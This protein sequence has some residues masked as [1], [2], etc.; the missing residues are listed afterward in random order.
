M[1]RD[2]RETPLVLARLIQEIEHRGLDYSGLYIRQL[3]YSI[4]DDRIS[5]MIVFE[6]EITI[7]V[8]IAAIYEKVLFQLLIRKY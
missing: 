6:F 8:K 4:F 1:A 3:F 2:R 5:N 7:I